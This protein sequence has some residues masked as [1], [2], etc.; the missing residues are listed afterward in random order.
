MNIK[1]YI[2]PILTAF[3][4][5][6]CSD[7]LEQAPTDVHFCIKAAWSNGRGVDTRAAISSLFADA[8]KTD[9]VIAPEDYPSEIDVECNG[10]TFTLIKPTSL[11]V[12]DTHTGF[13]HGYTSS[14]PL[15]DI[16]AKKGVTATA[17]M[18]GGDELYCENNDIELDGT[19]LKFTMHHKKTLLRFAFMVSD[20]YDQIRYIKITGIKFN[21]TDCAIVE[22]VLS[23]SSLRLIAYAYI[24]PTSFSVTKQNTLACTY[25]I[26][27]KDA[28]FD[29]S[30]TESALASHLTREG[31]VAQ[32]TFKLS[33]ASSNTIS[34]LKAGYYYD[35]NITLNPDYLYVLSE[36]DNKHIVIN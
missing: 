5:V 30:M 4:A 14:Y 29:G 11:T 25:N 8:N 13:F 12:C 2:L 1:S 6:A 9:L 19:H 31:V 10:K 34:E 36:H 3:F 16:E 26:Y 17:T 28:L 18:D 27:D 33:D 22:K 35:L 20:K 23:K 7:D 21:D 15:K 24:D 32:N